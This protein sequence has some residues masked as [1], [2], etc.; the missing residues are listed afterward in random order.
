MAKT[1]NHKIHRVCVWGEGG[2]GNTGAKE[3]LGEKSLEALMYIHQ[4]RLKDEDARGSEK[5]RNFPNSTRLLA[6]VTLKSGPCP[7]Y[8]GTLPLL[9]EKSKEGGG[10]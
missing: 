3:T 8:Q 10:S 1:S 5:L 4:P 7:L 6:D 2:V 9:P